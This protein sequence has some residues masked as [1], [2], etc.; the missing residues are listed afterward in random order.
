VKKEEEEEEG[1]PHLPLFSPPGLPPLSL[2][3]RFFVQLQM[4]TDNNHKKRALV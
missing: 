1:A 2:S 4:T 3:L